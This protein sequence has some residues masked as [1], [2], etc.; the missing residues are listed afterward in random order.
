MTDQEFRT[1]ADRELEDLHE[2]LAAAMEQFPIDIDYNAGALTIEF[3][4]TPAKFVV[5]PNAPVKQIWVSANLKS[6]KLD[7]DEAKKA[8]VTDGKTLAKLVGDAIAVQLKQE[9]VL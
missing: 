3:E 9:V 7:W 5:S 4:E 6:Y 1:V 2:R 8:F